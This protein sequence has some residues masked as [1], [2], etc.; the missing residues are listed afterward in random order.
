MIPKKIDVGDFVSGSTNSLTSQQRLAVYQFLSTGECVVVMVTP[1]GVSL[2]WSHPRLVMVTRLGLSLPWPLC[3]S[4][5]IVCR[6]R[7]FHKQVH[8][9]FCIEASADSKE[10]S[11]EDIL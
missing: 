10:R 7:A 8:D 1:L 6:S 2:S 11:T 4:L 5:S 9:Q 3:D